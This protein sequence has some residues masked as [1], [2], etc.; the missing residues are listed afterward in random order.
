MHF[1]H[2]ITHLLCTIMDTV[3]CCVRLWIPSVV[4]YHSVH[5]CVV[6]C[7]VSFIKLVHPPLTEHASIKK[8]LLVHFCCVLILGKLN[9]SCFKCT[10]IWYSARYFLL[11]AFLLITAEFFKIT[12]VAVGGYANL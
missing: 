1:C 4:V 8:Q 3:R 12:Q 2:G 6:C 9:I 11:S 7:I 10:R 5:S